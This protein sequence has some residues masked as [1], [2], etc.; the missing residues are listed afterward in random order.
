MGK[1]TGFAAAGLGVVAVGVAGGTFLVSK[2]NYD[3]YEKSYN[4]GVEE[5]KA[6]FPALPESVFIDND[7]ISYSGGEVSSSKSNFQNA[8]VYGV[9]SKDVSIA[10]LNKD[11]AG[12]IEKLDEN[13][14]A[15]S[16][17]YTGLDARGGAITFNI[18]TEKYGTAD[19]EIALRTNWVDE[20]G[21]YHELK[22]ITDYIKIQINKLEVKTEEQELPADRESFTSLILKGTHLIP[23][24]NTLTL[25]T[26]AY[27]D[28]GNKDNI[29]YVMPDIRN[30]TVLTDTT[31]IQTSAEAE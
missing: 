22:N 31:I 15:L 10:P 14:N 18:N 19:I 16:E 12:K 5:V 4:K 21:E 26:S 8:Y 29:L 23:G 28:Y 6:N 7:F 3:H 9:S 24:L 1:I 11:R 2:S 30:V 13:E 20:K 27:N 25:T 17:Y